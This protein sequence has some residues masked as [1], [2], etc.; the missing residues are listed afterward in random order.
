MKI[1]DVTNDVID[2][3]NNRELT[4]YNK[5]SVRQELCSRL[6]K[7]LRK[8]YSSQKLD[9]GIQCLQSLQKRA[10]DDCTQ[11][12]NLVKELQQ[13]QTSVTDMMISGAFLL[14]V[15]ACPLI[16]ATAL[17]VT[18]GVQGINIVGKYACRYQALKVAENAVEVAK[19]KCEII[20]DLIATMNGC[21]KERLEIEKRK[22]LTLFNFI[23]E[24]VQ[25][26]DLCCN[27]MSQNAPIIIILAVTATS[28]WLQYIFTMGVFA[29]TSN[30]YQADYDPLP[31][32]LRS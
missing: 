5:D 29:E 32:N 16:G 21:Y 12:V 11:A 8:G 22:S 25:Q 23:P 13:S 31:M 24:T 14:S 20:R 19:L 1:S 17:G 28:F 18:G 7:Q 4:P 27:K 30:F 2:Q 10:D 9:Y 3:L 15:I 26:F 6:Q